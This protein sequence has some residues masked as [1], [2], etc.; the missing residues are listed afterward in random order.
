MANVIDRTHRIGID[1]DI[2]GAISLAEIAVIRWINVI[3]QGR[4]QVISVS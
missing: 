2:D 1:V 3:Y 4:R